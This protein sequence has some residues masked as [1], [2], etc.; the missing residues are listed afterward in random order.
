MISAS[1]AGALRAAESLRRVNL[2]S[3]V[4]QAEST[5]VTEAEVSN[6]DVPD[7]TG[8]HDTHGACQPRKISGCVTLNLTYILQ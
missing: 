8:T 3:V 5:S 6:D 2:K 1:V 4:A 7:I